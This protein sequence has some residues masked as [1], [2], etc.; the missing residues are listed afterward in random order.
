M[1]KPVALIVNPSAG[2]GRAGGLLP[3]YEAA[4]RS[5]GL[6][7]RVERTT[8]LVHADE[9][10]REAVTNGEV[11][12]ALGGDGLIGSVVGALRKVPG[13]LLGVLPGGRGNDLARVLGIPR[14]AVPAGAR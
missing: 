7:H 4:L 6:E 10:A 9:L 12:A 5:L 11:A 8:G 1:A 2:G 3:R 14:E 13:A